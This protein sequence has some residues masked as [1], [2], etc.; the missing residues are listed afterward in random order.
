M[1][2]RR[3]VNAAR[4]QIALALNHHPGCQEILELQHKHPGT[5][6]DRSEAPGTQ[7]G[8]V[9]K[10]SWQADSC[11]LPSTPV[12]LQTQAESYALPTTPV[13]LQSKRLTGPRP[14]TSPS[15]TTNLKFAGSG[16]SSPLPVLLPGAARRRGIGSSSVSCRGVVESSVAKA[17]KQQESPS[18]K[19][20]HAQLNDRKGAGCQV[21]D[22][23]MSS[24]AK[25]PSIAETSSCVPPD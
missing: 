12:R 21:A 22:P 4:Q 7:L 20:C 11:S 6:Q 24:H 5:L 23:G 25:L 2:E 16:L 3:D 18:L 13:R 14:K 8:K 15:G 19:Q 17:S 10:S 1:L 9:K